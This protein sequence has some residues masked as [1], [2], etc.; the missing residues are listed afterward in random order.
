MLF[1]NPVFKEL[2]LLFELL[3]KLK[4]NLELLEEYL[5][6]ERSD[7]E[8][9][10]KEILQ[11][12][13]KIQKY[14]GYELDFLQKANLSKHCRNLINQVRISLTGDQINAIFSSGVIP[15]SAKIREIKDLIGKVLVAEKLIEEAKQDYNFELKQ[16]AKAEALAKPRLSFHEPGCYHFLRIEKLTSVFGVGL[17]SNEALIQLHG[18]EKNDRKRYSGRF[19]GLSNISV[20]DP[21]SYFKLCLSLVKFGK[22]ES[23]KERTITA[24]DLSEVFKNN[25]ELNMS[26]FAEENIRC[27]LG[28]ATEKELYQIASGYHGG[29]LGIERETIINSFLLPLENDF[30]TVMFGSHK[31]N[32]G[33]VI[34]ITAHLI[35][36]HID[37]FLCEALFIGKVSADKIV[38]IFAG[39]DRDALYLQE[40]AKFVGIP[41]Y[42]KNGELIWPKQ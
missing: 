18:A 25:P 17:L 40:F 23:L 2:R 22:I 26:K 39:N 37:F 9:L 3:T 7:T 20:F 35:P 10:E 15:K 14:R 31:Q 24:N 28:K 19:Q 27:L 1:E 38:G 34:N 4:N 30:S 41:L 6:A 21:Y 33:L 16:K 5:L 32:P 36:K 12:I 11:I 42:G 13:S 8:N 29:L